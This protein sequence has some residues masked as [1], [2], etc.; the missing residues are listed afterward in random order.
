MGHGVLD[1]RLRRCKCIG[2]D[3]CM[4]NY[5]PFSG[6]VQMYRF[7]WING[8]TALPDYNGLSKMLQLERRKCIVPASFSMTWVFC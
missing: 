8:F 6:T 7:D 3:E 1:G 5:L 4:T 2:L